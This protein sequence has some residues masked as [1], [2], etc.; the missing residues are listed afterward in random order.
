ML[1]WEDPVEQF[2]SPTNPQRATAMLATEALAAV[3]RVEAEVNKAEPV[4][5]IEAKAPSSTVDRAEPIGVT[6]LEQVEF[7]AG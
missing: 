2:K 1:N 4:G 7:G 3:E 6:G 5:E